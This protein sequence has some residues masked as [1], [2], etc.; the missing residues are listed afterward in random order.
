ME[1]VSD[2]ENQLKL[3]SRKFS[4]FSWGY[5]LSFNSILECSLTL[6]FYLRRKPIWAHSFVSQLPLIKSG[7]GCACWNHKFGDS[8]SCLASETGETCSFSD[9]RLRVRQPSG[10]ESWFGYLF[11]VWCWMKFFFLLAM[12]FYLWSRV[13][14]STYL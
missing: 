13:V 7:L 8:Q 14:C 12:H 2:S 11:T 4:S 5:D 10:L 3:E 1:W 6:F 9:P